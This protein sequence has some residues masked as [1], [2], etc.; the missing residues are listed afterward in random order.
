[1]ASTHKAPAMR[2]TPIGANAGEEATSPRVKR[3]MPATRIAADNH[4]FQLYFLP[5]I[6]TEKAITGMIFADLNTIRVA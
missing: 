2:I 5:T 1:M 3:T 6:K 4:S